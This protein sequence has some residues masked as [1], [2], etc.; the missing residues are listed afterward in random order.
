[1]LFASLS[2]ETFL[3]RSGGAGGFG[4][5]PQLRRIGK[6]V[7][8][9]WPCN[10]TTFRTGIAFSDL[11]NRNQ[12]DLITAVNNFLKKAIKDEV[13][14]SHFVPISVDETSDIQCPLSEPGW[15]TEEHLLGFS[16]VSK[17][18]TAAKLKEE[19]DY[20]LDEYQSREKPI[21]QTY[22]GASVLLRELQSGLR[23]RVGKDLTLF[24]FTAVAHIEFGLGSS[25]FVNQGVSLFVKTISGL[26]AFFKRTNLMDTIF[27][28]RIHTGTAVRCHYHARLI[29]AVL[30]T[31]EKLVE[32]Y[33]LQ[34][35]NTLW[36]TTTS[37]TVKH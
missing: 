14:S 34:H 1:M 9:I 18:R 27:G 37:L 23:T 20:T 36:N 6:S 16:D 26:S 21:P 35:I 10:G 30:E 33:F 19:V 24:L 7:M 17:D 3:Q 32:I 13:I 31:R 29:H 28:R 12:N 2:T 5:L 15:K 11:C 22:N 25:Y 8:C 4:Q